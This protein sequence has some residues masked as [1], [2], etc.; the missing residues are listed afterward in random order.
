MKFPVPSIR[1]WFGAKNQQ[2]VQSSNIVGDHNYIEQ[3]IN[4]FVANPAEWNQSLL[5]Q[6]T[7]KK[8]FSAEQFAIEEEL[9][10]SEDTAEI[11]RILAYRKI[12][13]DGDSEMAIKLLEGLKSE[14]EYQSGFVAFRLNYNIGLILQNIGEYD[15]AIEALKLSYSFCPSLPKAKSALAFA[16]LLAGHDEAALKQASELL[17]IEGD[18]L[19]ICAVIALHAAKRLKRNFASEDFQLC[20]ATHPEVIVARL[21]HL[22]VLRPEQFTDALNEAWNADKN[23]EELAS[24]WALAVL[25]DAQQNQAFLLGA[26]TTD[27]FES[28]INK[29]AD[30]LKQELDSALKLRPP[31]MLLLSSQAN[32]AAVALRLAGRSNEAERVLDRTLAKAPDLVGELAHIKAVFLL[33]KDRDLEA[34][35]IISPLLDHP[36]MQVM[37]SEIEAKMGEPANALNRINSV[38]KKG[39]PDGLLLHALASKARI[40]INADNRDAADEALDELAANFASSSELIHLKSAY[41]RAFELKIVCDDIELL[42]DVNVGPSANEKQLLSSLDRRDDWSFFELL[43]IANELFARGFYRESADLLRDR[44]NFRRESPALQTL[45]DACLRG[46]LG[47]LGRLI[48]DRL[49]PEIKNSVFGWKFCA[50]IGILTGEIAQIVP[51]TRKLFEGNSSSLSALF[52][53]VQSLLRVN[54]KSRIRRLVRD[55]DDDSLVGTVAEKR[56]YINL[57]VFCD[58]LT[59]AR[60]LAYQL[61]CE[62]QNDHRSWMALS[63]SVLTL[64]R[65][66]ASE[67]VLSLT[68]VAVDAAFEV[69]LPNGENRKF[70]LEDSPRLIHLRQENIPLDHPIARA[71]VGCKQGE[72]FFWPLDNGATLAT[73]ISVKHKALD[74]FHFALQRFEEKFPDAD[75]FKSIKC[76]PSRED[77]L[78]EIKSMLIQRAQYGQKK[79]KEYYEGSYPLS[80][81]G[82]HLGLDSIDTYLGLHRECSVAVK[83]ST[84]NQID[85]DAAAAA[86]SLGRKNGLLLDALSVYLLRRLDLIEAVE[87]EFGRIGITQFTLDTFAKRA[88]AAEGMGSYDEDGQRRSGHLSSV[89]GQIILSEMNE[90]EINAKLK[91]IY[92]DLDWLKANC[93]LIPAVAQDDPPSEIIRFRNEK[94]GGFFDDLFA[95]DGSGRILIS[96]DYSLCQWGGGLFQTP[97][98]WIQ[99]L[100]FHLEEAEQISTAQVVRATI[101]L[102]EAGEEALSINGHRLQIGAEMFGNGELSEEE[103]QCLCRLIGQTGAYIPSHLSVTLETLN[104]L[105]S[106][107]SLIGVR[108]KVTSMLLLMLTRNQGEESRVILDTIYSRVR[109]Y[110]ARSYIEGWRIGHFI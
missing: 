33:E 55:L 48:R 21:E 30:I 57:L 97:S 110:A 6:G 23:S 70:I 37:A 32:N 34:F 53:H 49:S 83:V 109:S 79:A 82:F 10:S 59:R 46:N 3:N 22:R 96:D 45:C 88:H 20:D 106:T 60:S 64:G 89:N 7:P 94:G 103:F 27:A 98:A 84:C 65:P 41:E 72:K 101:H 102:L 28:D 63:A 43:Q 67:D 68:K 56:E 81:L 105:W 78:D 69:I 80:I 38:L 51:L 75:G 5:V 17:T 4:V 61:F 18:H 52:W 44:V 14:K 24:M 95:C 58:E 86:L 93:D 47:T 1:S 99:S 91:L 92:S 90:G 40:G 9:I 108:Q 50:N 74:A 71:A 31:N 66:V 12:A 107:T 76:D 77:G 42:P 85:Q 13:T 2:N 29:S 26:K 16:E 19:N 104:G 35:Q 15:K 39:I 100:L 73:V 8:H 36:E 62:N 11:K 25:D 54:D 87:S